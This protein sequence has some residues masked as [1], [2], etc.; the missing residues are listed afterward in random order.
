MGKIDLETL[1]NEVTTCESLS[2][3]RDC[4]WGKCADCG[5]VPLLYKLGIG[6]TLEEPDE[7]LEAKK[8][9]LSDI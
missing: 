9:F 5:V 4:K 3:K 8:K 7:I 1:E 2:K 6:K